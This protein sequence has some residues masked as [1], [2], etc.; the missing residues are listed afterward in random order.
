MTTHDKWLWVLLSVCWM[1]LLTHLLIKCQRLNSII[2]TK[3]P[4]CFES[5]LVHGGVRPQLFQT[6]TEITEM[7]KTVVETL[8]EIFVYVTHS[9]KIDWKYGLVGF[10]VYMSNITVHQNDRY[11]ENI[12]LPI[13]LQWKQG[14]LSAVGCLTETRKTWNPKQSWINKTRAIMARCHCGRWV[15][16]YVLN[17]FNYI[18]CLFLFLNCPKRQQGLKSV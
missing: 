15:R 14:L 2:I 18:P 3:R 7:T 9:K 16:K 10:S 1:G 5:W 12:V 6:D 13:V 11:R 17:Y 8:V 4:P